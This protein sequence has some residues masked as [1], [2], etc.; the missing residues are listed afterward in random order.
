MLKQLVEKL[1]QLSSRE[2]FDASQFNDPV[3]AQ[4]DWSPLKGGGTNFKTHSLKQVHAQRME[5]R[6]S[7]G[8]KLFSGVFMTFGA[9]AIA[10]A[11]IAYINRNQSTETSIFIILPIFGLVF[12]GVGY[13]MLRSAAVP[14]VFDVSLGYYCRD[15][16]KPEH[17]FDTSRIK[18]HVRLD[19]IHALQLIAEYV[20][21]N[22]SSY[23]SYELNLVLKDGS[24]INVVDHGGH[25]AIVKDAETLS[26]F[27][28]V[29]LWSTL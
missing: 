16:R 10:G 15:R 14:R 20:R 18:D 12:G 25:S 7:I 9:G 11:V 27:L 8:M 23:H 1:K 4:I 17:S 26:N 13:L 21:G 29:P 2:P 6:S 24:R 28:G 5:F 22:K 19:Q 3:A